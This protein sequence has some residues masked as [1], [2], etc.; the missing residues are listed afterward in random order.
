[1]TFPLQSFIIVTA[2]ATCKATLP[3]PEP[4]Y[5]PTPVLS[6][7]DM[8]STVATISGYPEYSGDYASSITGTLV[9]ENK[10]TG[11]HV[12]GTL[13]GVE[14]SATGAGIHIHSGVSCD[15]TS[16]PGGHYYPSMSVDPWLT[17]TYDSDTTGVATVSL[18]VEDFSL[19]G[20]NPVAGRTIVV[21]DSSG[22]R[23]GC[24]VLQTT[25]GQIVSVGAYPA[26]S[27][28]YTVTGTLVVTNFLSNKKNGIKIE[29]TLGGLE[30]S[31]DGGIH[32]HSGFTCDET[33]DNNGASVVGTSV[34]GHYYDKNSISTD[35]W[36]KT[37]TYKAH[38]GSAH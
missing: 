23:I 16:G 30:A 33:E 37:T 32:I 4:T 15:S 3:T 11:I 36:D 27:T 22:I 28:D 8:A 13:A 35:P 25:A 29:G 7:D 5:S 17:T 21:H 26:S 14:A 10:E 18:Q 2:F 38:H 34:G 12:Y 1:M 19:G 9:V 31:K 20:T 24:G 6:R